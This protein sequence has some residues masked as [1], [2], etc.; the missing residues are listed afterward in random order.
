MEKSVQKAGKYGTS[1]E[2]KTG[3]RGSGTLTVLLEFHTGQN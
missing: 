3:W 2:Q 1:T